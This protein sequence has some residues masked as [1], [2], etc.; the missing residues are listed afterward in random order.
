[1]SEKR[2]EYQTY[3]NEIKQAAEVIWHLGYDLTQISDLLAVAISTLRS[4]K[5]R[6]NWAKQEP[7]NRAETMAEKWYPDSASHQD[8]YRAGYKQG[9]E[10]CS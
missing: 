5:T 8:A 1:M 7:K 9:Q 10:D 3:N 6:Y 2:E 4:W